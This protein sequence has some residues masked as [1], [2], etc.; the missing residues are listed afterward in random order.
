MA[1][2][3]AE[4]AARA[5]AAIALNRLPISGLWP[6]LIHEFSPGISPDPFHPVIEP[7][8]N[9]YPG[10]PGHGTLE[11]LFES[12]P[13]P[14]GYPRKQGLFRRSLRFAGKWVPF[15]ND[16]MTIVGS[17]RAIAKATEYCR[18]LCEDKLQADG[19]LLAH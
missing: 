5:A 4:I 2:K 11:E 3:L 9:W 17:V 6:T 12:Y 10:L 19:N 14:H 13:G 1:L 15:V 18:G 8:E 16:A 7:A